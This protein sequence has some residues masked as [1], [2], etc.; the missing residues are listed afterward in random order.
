MWHLFTH[1]SGLSYGFHHAHPVDT[2]YREAGFEW[3]MPPGK[4]LEGV[5]DIYASLPL[6]FQPGSEWNYSVSPGRA[7]PRHRGPDRPV[8]RPRVRGAPVRA[9]GHDADRVPGARG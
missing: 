6:L 8:A 7:G 4:D 1:T 3:G 9:A 2:L 5:C